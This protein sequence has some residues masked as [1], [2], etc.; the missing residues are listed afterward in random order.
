MHAELH[1]VISGQAELLIGWARIRY[2]HELGA[3]A[4]RHPVRQLVGTLA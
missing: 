3:S 4:S 2:C 1:R